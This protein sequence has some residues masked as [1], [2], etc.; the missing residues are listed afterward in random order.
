ML[1][2]PELH[3]AG[4]SSAYAYVNVHRINCRSKK[5]EDSMH[6]KEHGVPH[7]QSMH[8]H[9]QSPLRISFGVL[10]GGTGRKGC[11]F[12]RTGALATPLPFSARQISVLLRKEGA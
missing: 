4:F 5:A 9:T 1:P 8:S 3:S 12:V 2:Y 11:Q 10:G 7:L 6:E